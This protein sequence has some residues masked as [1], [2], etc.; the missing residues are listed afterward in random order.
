MG[1]S[2]GQLT[3]ADADKLARMERMVEALSRISATPP[4][5]INRSG[6]NP[7]IS[8]GQVNIPLLAEVTAVSG[9][10]YTVKRKTRDS[11]NAVVDL[12]PVQSIENVITADGSILTVGQQVFIQAIPDWPLPMQYWWAISV[13]GT[14]GFCAEPR[15]LGWL[16]DVPEAT[17][18]QIRM[19]GGWGRFAD[20]PTESRALAGTAVYISGFGL[21]GWLASKM[22]TTCCGCGGALF[23]I[24]GE[25]TATLQLMG[26]HI[27]CLTSSGIDAIATIDMKME[28]GAAA[29]DPETGE[30]MVTFVSNDA[31]ACNG[32]LVECENVF[33]M[34]V[35]CYDCPPPNCS[36]VCVGESPMS[37]YYD[38]LNTFADEEWNGF[39]VIAYDDTAVDGCTWVGYCEPTTI[40]STLEFVNTP[41]SPVWRL[42]HGTAIYEIAKS[43]WSPSGSNTLTYVSGAPGAHPATITIAPVIPLDLTTG[44][45]DPNRCAP[46]DTLTFSIDAPD[47]PLLDGFTTTVTRTGPSS[48]SWEWTNP[49]PGG[50]YIGSV[51]IGCVDGGWIAN[52]TG[53]CSTG[54]SPVGM[55]AVNAPDSQ[56]FSPLELIWLNVDISMVDPSPDPACCNLSV[57]TI[58]VTE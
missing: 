7:V 43:S 26:I 47:C 30:P 51:S 37:W 13:V 6:F 44:I 16:L 19:T 10:T 45:P 33:R 20:I 29:C 22:K 36:C 54:P 31:R 39:W 40:T 23:Q 32:D 1:F 49:S 27:S 46:P 53:T 2:P 18:L 11:T 24:T 58:T 8:L 3:R 34:T 17:C 4:L 28:P 25:F 12:L 14:G 35:S 38:V 15:G 57:G 52:V 55:D 5:S 42:T 48:N 41:G 21:T 9:T 50:S 56:T